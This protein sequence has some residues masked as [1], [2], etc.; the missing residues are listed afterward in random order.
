MSFTIATKHAKKP[1]GKKSSSEETP[2]LTSAPREPSPLP[3][4]G[5]AFQTL[6]GTAAD[7]HRVHEFLTRVFHGPSTEAFATSLED[8]FYEPCNRLLLRLTRGTR[9]SI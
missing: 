2:S 8:P 7:H 9:S 5:S 3:L 4:I 6:P 1:S